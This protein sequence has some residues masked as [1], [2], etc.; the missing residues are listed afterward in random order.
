MLPR[1]PARVSS[2]DIFIF[3]ILGISFWPR[4]EL[5]SFQPHGS[6]FKPLTAGAANP[7]LP[8]CL[9]FERQLLRKAGVGH[10][11]PCLARA[12]PARW[13]PQ[14]S[15]HHLPPDALASNRHDVAL[16]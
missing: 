10:G 4:E 15:P 6:A 16:L 14:G 11:F 1:P 8:G 5:T 13:L 7:N 3:K 9:V 12:L 2:S